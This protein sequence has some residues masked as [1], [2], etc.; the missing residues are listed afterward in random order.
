MAMLNASNN[1]PHHSRHGRRCAQRWAPDRPLNAK[2]VGGDM[3]IPCRIIK[4]G[5]A[6][7]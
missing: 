6:H 1:R 4:I 3:D 5:R 7:V 2:I